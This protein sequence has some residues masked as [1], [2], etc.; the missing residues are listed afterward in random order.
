[1]G[2][3]QTLTKERDYW[4]DNAK[5]FLVITVV[6]GHLIE[7]IINQTEFTGAYS[8]MQTIYLSIYTFHMPVFLIILRSSRR[9]SASGGRFHAAA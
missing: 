5:A 8:W 9:Q 6:I 7:T 3:M 1:M 4:F 2:N